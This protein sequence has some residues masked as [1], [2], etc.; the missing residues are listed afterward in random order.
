MVAQRRLRVVD[1]ALWYGERS[2]VVRVIAM[3]YRAIRMSSN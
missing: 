2:G 3:A 1:V